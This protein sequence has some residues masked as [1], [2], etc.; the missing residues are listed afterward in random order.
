MAKVREA[1]FSSLR[2]LQDKI[3]LDVFAGSGSLGLEALSRGAKKSYFVEGHPQAVTSIITNLKN[4]GFEDQAK[5]YK[6]HLPYG[7]KSIKLT[8]TPQIIFCD[9]PYEKDLLNK[10]LRALVKYKL[11]DRHSCLIVEHTARE[12]PEVTELE[13]FKEKK[14]GQTF[15]TFLKL[16]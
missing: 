12:R 15:I 5:V 6:R 7:L 11:I 14:Y 8:E 4:L 2:D 1:I 13:V 16:K 3:V 9:P 10:T